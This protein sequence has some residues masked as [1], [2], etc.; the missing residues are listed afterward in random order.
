MTM[1][2]LYRQQRWERRAEWPLAGVAFVFLVVFSVEVLARPYGFT[3]RL[4]GWIMLALYVVFA[5]DYVVRL[6]LAQH[7]TRWFFRHLLDFV[8]IALPFVQPLRLL[9]LVVLVEVMEKLFGDAFRGRI[10]VYTAVSAILLIYSGS[11]G[12]LAAERTNPR[13]N[14]KTFGDAVLVGDHNTYH[15]GIRRP[16]SDHGIGPGDR[17]P[18]DAGRDQSHRHRCRDG[19]D[20]DG[21]EFRRRRRRRAGCDSRAD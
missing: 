18:V 14:I 20:L 13:T 10:V 4:L 9:R 5:I 21:A 3:S 12:V 6:V 15:S 2:T 16:L 7:R 11:L 1:S 8:I 19:R 17:G